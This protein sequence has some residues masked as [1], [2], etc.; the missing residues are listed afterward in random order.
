M[1]LKFE[2][3]S[4]LKLNISLL[5]AY[6]LSVEITCP[7]AAFNTFVCFLRILDEHFED[8]LNEL[9]RQCPKSRQTMLFSATMTDQVR[10]GWVD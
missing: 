8:Q 9:I 1:Y 7:Y 10:G 2:W 3:I 5:G 4:L 6:F